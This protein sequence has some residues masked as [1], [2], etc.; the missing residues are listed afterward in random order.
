MGLVHVGKNICDSLPPGFTF[1]DPN[2][3]NSLHYDDEFEIVYEKEPEQTPFKESSWIFPSD[4]VLAWQYD[5]MNNHKDE[6]YFSL[7]SA[8]T[9]GIYGCND[10]TGLN[11]RFYQ[12][13][14]QYKDAAQFKWNQTVE[15]FQKHGQWLEYSAGFKLNAPYQL[16]LR[17]RN[18]AETNFN[19]SIFKANG[20]TA[21]FYDFNLQNDFTN[22]GGGNGGCSRQRLD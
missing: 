17:A 4:T 15:T 14:I 22:K 6:R 3:D 11:V 20:D 7:D 10:T 12:D 1:D 13:S 9:I 21:F 2:K 19:V 16:L 18:N 8:N 5:V